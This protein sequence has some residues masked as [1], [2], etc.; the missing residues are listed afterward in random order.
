MIHVDRVL[1]SLEA[2]QTLYQD[3]IKPFLAKRLITLW[4]VRL[5]TTLPVFLAESMSLGTTGNTFEID[6]QVQTVAGSRLYSHEEQFAVMHDRRFITPKLADGRDDTYDVMTPGRKITGTHIAVSERSGL[7][8][9]VIQNPDRSHSILLPYLPADQWLLL[10]EN[11]NFIP[12]TRSSPNESRAST[13]I[14]QIIRH[15]LFRV[16]REES[17][18][19]PG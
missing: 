10:D 14:V 6:W 4:G 17:V 19:T 15:Y 1:T 3:E 11:T 9:N 18:I 16:P 7:P 13:Y 5:P 12:S 2:A 8:Y